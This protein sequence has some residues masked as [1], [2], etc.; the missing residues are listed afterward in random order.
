MSILTKCF[1]CCLHK[2]NILIHDYLENDSNSEYIR[3]INLI[4]QYNTEI[5]NIA[6]LLDCVNI[7]EALKMIDENDDIE[8]MVD[9]LQKYN[10]FTKPILDNIK[11]VIINYKEGSNKDDVIIKLINDNQLLDDTIKSKNS[12]IKLC[13]E[14]HTYLQYTLD[15]LYNELKHTKYR[16]KNLKHKM[17]RSSLNPIE[18]NLKY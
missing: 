14:K 10:N 17:Y 4:K 2:E 1:P 11:D 15:N 7:N 6:I 12:Y 18:E 9:L 5:V 3:I 16:P 13:E 8:H